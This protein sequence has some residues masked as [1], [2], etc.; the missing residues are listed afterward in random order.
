[1]YVENSMDCAK[2]T[3]L[4]DISEFSKIAGYKSNMQNINC[5]SICQQ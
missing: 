1:M 4:S 2:Q 5:I 3:K